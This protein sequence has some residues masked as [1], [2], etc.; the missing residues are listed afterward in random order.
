MAVY[1]DNSMIAHKG[2]R[3]CHLTT[4]SAEGL[5]ELHEFAAKLGLRR[6][7][8][9]ERP[10][11][12]FCHYDVTASKRRQA[13]E[14]GAVDETWQEAAQR[15]IAAAHAQMMGEKLPEE[16]ISVRSCR[17]CGCTSDRACW[18]DEY[19]PCAWADADLCTACIDDA[20]DSWERTPSFADLGYE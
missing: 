4:D 5:E 11:W 20:G 13:I 19:G 14:L 9:Q 17:E 1:V 8:F 6:E 7:W 12:W 18:H 10:Q 16:E 3:W 2:R 15:A